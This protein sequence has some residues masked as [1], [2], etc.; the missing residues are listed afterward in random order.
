MKK[1][2]IAGISLLAVGLV[3]CIFAGYKIFV[4]NREYKASITFYS[5]QEEKFVSKEYIPAE[6]REKLKIDFSE[7][8][9]TNED[10]C[11]WISIPSIDI[12]YPVLQGENND[13]YL[14]HLPDGKYNI[15]GSIFVDERCKNDFTS[16]VTIIYGHYM[17]NGTMFG[18]LNRFLDSSFMRANDTF[19]IYTDNEIITAHIIT[20]F[21]T[22][23][24]S[25]IYKLPDG[26]LNEYISCLTEESNADFSE[27]DSEKMNLII[28][29]T[30]SHSFK[31]ARTVVV[32]SKD[33]Q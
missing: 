32:A 7:L 11:G 2:K 29:S 26:E 14:R 25:P 16:P 13:T 9:K 21:E 30:C 18:R 4:I 12:S 22:K 33:I 24:S 20:C 8:I 23:N 19:E 10:I 31:S 27:F 17:N 6:K 5:E 15:A 1:K 3:I 28:L